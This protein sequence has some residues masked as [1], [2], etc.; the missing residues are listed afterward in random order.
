MNKTFVKICLALF[1]E[2]R[3][4]KYVDDSKII[5]WTNNT[6]NNRITVS[7]KELLYRHIP[8]KLSLLKWNNYELFQSYFDEIKSFNENMEDITAYL[9]EEVNNLSLYYPVNTVVERH[10]IKIRTEE[11]K[12]IEKKSVNIITDFLEPQIQRA[13][14]GV[15]YAYNRVCEADVRQLGFAAIISIILFINVMLFPTISKVNDVGNDSTKKSD[16][17][18]LSVNNGDTEVILTTFVDDTYPKNIR[19]SLQNTVYN[20]SS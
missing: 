11:N 20:D 15:V 1:P 19:K 3:S 12:E 9:K 16:F 14:R 2:F 6:F 8:T 4:G 18:N 5:F 10:I 17:I 13:I 7:L